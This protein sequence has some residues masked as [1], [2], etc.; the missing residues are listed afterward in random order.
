MKRGFLI[1]LCS[2]FLL[3]GMAGYSA[4]A[5][6]AIPG[7]TVSWWSLIFERPNPERLP[8]RVHY[9]WAEKY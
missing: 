4:A 8:V 7:A 1:I 6:K 9:Y 5:P 2:I 3:A